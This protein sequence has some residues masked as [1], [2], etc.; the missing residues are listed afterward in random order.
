MCERVVSQKRQ[1]S[2]ELQKR[3]EEFR[4]SCD[5][6]IAASKQ[7]LRLNNETKVWLV[8]SCR[9]WSAELQKQLDALDRGETVTTVSRSVDRT[10]RQLIIA[11]KLQSAKISV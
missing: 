10:V 9:E 11:L 4:H 5:T 3:L 2:D 8:K 7:Q 1:T 6:L